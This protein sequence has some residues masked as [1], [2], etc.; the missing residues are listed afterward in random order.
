ML[1]EVAAKLGGQ[2]LL[3]ARASWRRDLVGLVDWRASE[4]ERLGVA[5]HL[6]RF[7][8]EADVLAE[9]P[10]VVVIATG[11]LPH[12]GWIEGGEHCTGLWDLLAGAAAPEGDCLVYD[13][14][15]RHGALTAAEALVAA[16]RRV[17]FVA[18]DDHLA[19]E[20][21]YAEQ[22]IWKRRAYE[23]GLRPDFDR[24]LIKVERRGNKLAAILENELTGA[25]EAR[26]SD[27]VLIEAGTL[28][29][30]SLYDALRAQANNQGVTDLNSLLRG[31]PQPQDGAAG[32]A[33]FRIGDAVASRNIAAA[34]YDALRLCRHF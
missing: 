7:A 2:V 13:G 27:H 12:D 6:N 32:Y 20:M 11:G 34:V 1:F 15:G 16:G 31:R 17:D 9:T 22:V 33:L 28:P 23:L 5:V 8:E 25:R 3:A 24:R 18:L 29:A 10:D 26:L 19:M 21:A 4:L 30:A 14:T